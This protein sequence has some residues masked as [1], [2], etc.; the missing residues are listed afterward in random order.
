MEKLN[1]YLENDKIILRALEPEDLDVLFRWENDSELWAYGTTLAPYSKFALREYISEARNDI[2]QSRQ[3][4]LMIVL[5][6]NANA[7]GTIDL[8]DFDPVN[9]RAGVGI[10]LDSECRGKGFGS[11]VLNLIQD[12]A[13]NFLHLR[14]LYAHVPENNT[15]SMKLFANCGYTKSGSLKQ[16]LKCSDHFEDVNVMQLINPK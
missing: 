4:R 14:Q 12:Y 3:L 8:Y 10:L 13:F 9:L 2:F 7:I 6:E 15:A 16:W 11:Q 5:K 1:R